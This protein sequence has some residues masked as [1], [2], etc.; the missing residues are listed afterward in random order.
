MKVLSLG[1]DSFE[2]KE[3]EG[4]NESKVLVQVSLEGTLVIFRE[5]AAWRISR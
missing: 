5:K 2:R 3:Q 1:Y 4:E